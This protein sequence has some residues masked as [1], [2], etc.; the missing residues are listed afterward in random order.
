MRFRVMVKNVFL[1]FFRSNQASS[2]MKFLESSES[3]LKTGALTPFGESSED[4]G[5][6]SFILRFYRV[7]L[8]KLDVLRGRTCWFSPLRLSRQQNR[9]AVGDSDDSIDADGFVRSHHHR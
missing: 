7:R 9:P 3:D 5:S 8:D 1:S 4:V 2:S 6:E